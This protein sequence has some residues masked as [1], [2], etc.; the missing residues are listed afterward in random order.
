MNMANGDQRHRILILG[1]SG[2]IGSAVVSALETGSER[3]VVVRASRNRDQVDAWKHAGFEAVYLDLDDARTFAAA[4]QGVDRLFLLTGYTIA[5]VHQSKTIIDA[6]ADAGVRFIVHLGVFGNGRSTDPHFAWHEMIERYIEGSG[7]AWCH[8]HPHFFMENLITTLRFQNGRFFWPMS[9]KRIGW[10]AG[11]DVS[12]VAARI[13]ADGP[14]NHQGQNYWLSTDVLNGAEAAT[15]LS[16]ALNT[17]TEAAVM[18]PAEL[19]A[20]LASGAAAPI[21]TMESN[22]ARSAIEWVHQTYD[23]RMDYSSRATSTVQD[24]LGRPATHLHE[25]AARH[26]ST[27][28]Q[29]AS[30]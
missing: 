17:R 7:V 16:E 1:A 29:A 3:P 4:L 25:W 18:T 2:Q 10:I 20:L 13:L 23:G 24:L 8:L 26:R 15:I 30:G 27:L 11:E 21:S 14:A 12:A 19:M 22:Y 28:M 9:D 6:A 5:M